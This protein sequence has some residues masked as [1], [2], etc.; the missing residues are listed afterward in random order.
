M[1]QN[2]PRKKSTNISEWSMAIGS[3]IGL[4]ISITSHNPAYFAIGL[5]IGIAIGYTI[6]KRD[7][8]KR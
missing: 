7:E 3:L 1:A 6:D 8:N 4:V 5:A 2:N